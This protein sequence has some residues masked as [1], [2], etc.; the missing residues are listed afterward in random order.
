MTVLVKDIMVRQFDTIH[1]RVPVEQAIRM[2]L[3]GKVRYTGHKT[4]SLIVVNDLQQ[5]VGVITMFDILYHFRPDFLNFGIDGADLDWKGQIQLLVS[6]LKEKRVN[7]VMS[8][9]VIG[10]TPEE[11]LMVVIDRMVK[12]KYRRLPVLENR[13]PVGVV[14]ISDIY[15]HLF[16]NA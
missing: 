16:K 7:Q 12:N 5:M 15:H 8:D 1:E 3:N 4:V 11:H 2:V 10:A 9:N 13:K 6:K 14:Y